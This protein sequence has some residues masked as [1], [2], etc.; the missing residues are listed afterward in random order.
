MATGFDV[1]DRATC[2]PH[3][4]DAGSE[5]LE[6][7]TFSARH[8]LLGHP[9]I[10][11]GTVKRVLRAGTVKVLWDGDA[12]Q[13]S[14]N[15]THLTLVPDEMSSDSDSKVPTD[16]EATDEDVPDDTVGPQTEGGVGPAAEDRNINDTA[17]EDERDM[18]LPHL[19]DSPAIAMGDTVDSH[20]HSWKAS[21]TWG[22]VNGV[23]SRS[24]HQNC[25]GM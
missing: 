20:G 9:P 19:H 8:A 3:L 1:G 25:R 23:R 18:Q 15:S 11:Y 10:C 22:S 12:R 24:R 2:P 13:L 5:D 17:S 16:D 21:R 14:S 6:G 7:R 4:F